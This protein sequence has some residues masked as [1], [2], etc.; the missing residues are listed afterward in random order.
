MKM[1]DFFVIFCSTG[2]MTNAEFFAATY[3]ALRTKLGA[4]RTSTNGGMLRE[5]FELGDGKVIMFASPEQE[6][7]SPISETKKED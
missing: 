5:Y 2:T 7:P 3:L 4:P 1:L 6:T